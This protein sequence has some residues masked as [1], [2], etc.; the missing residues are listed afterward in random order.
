MLAKIIR[1]Y[2]TFRFLADRKQ[3]TLNTLCSVYK[4]NT[5][6]L[7]SLLLPVVVLPPGQ[8]VELLPVAAHGRQLLLSLHH[9][10]AMHTLQVRVTEGLVKM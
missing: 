9:I 1:K 8:E 5:K 10:T 2:T 7:T 4:K 3:K 6:T